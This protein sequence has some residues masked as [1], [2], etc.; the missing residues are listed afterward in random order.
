MFINFTYFI[1]YELYKVKINI[2]TN[3]TSIKSC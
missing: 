2:I 3:F 1:Y